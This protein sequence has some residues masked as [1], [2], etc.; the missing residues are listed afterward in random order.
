MACVRGSASVAASAWHPAWPLGAWRREALHRLD[1]GTVKA[2]ISLAHRKGHAAIGHQQH[3]G[4]IPA[5]R[6]GPE[7]TTPIRPVTKNVSLAYSPFSGN[8]ISAPAASREQA[9]P[10]PSPIWKKPPPRDPPPRRPLS[11]R[12]VIEARSAAMAISSAHLAH[13]ADHG[14]DGLLEQG[15]LQFGKLFALPQ[16]C[17]QRMHGGSGKKLG[18]RLAVARGTG[19]IAYRGNGISPTTA[20]ADASWQA[21]LGAGA[22]YRSPKRRILAS[23]CSNRHGRPTV[24]RR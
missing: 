11:S 17:S 24:R 9:T 4:R 20:C 12:I 10:T 7:S 23:P 13:P 14:R 8:E 19:A 3:A 5:D 2:G 16:P 18:A 6:R 21:A 22:S 15:R 1:E